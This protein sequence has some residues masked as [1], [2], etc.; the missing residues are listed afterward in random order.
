MAVSSRPPE[1]TCT[2]GSSWA[3]P[4]PA[5]AVR[6]SSS[7]A[8]CTPRQAVTMPQ[9]L[10]L[11]FHHHTHP[12]CGSL[13]EATRR[14]ACVRKK[15]PSSSGSSRSGSHPDGMLAKSGCPMI[16]TMAISRS[17]CAIPSGRGMWVFCQPDS[18][19]TWALST[20]VMDTRSPP[21]SVDGDLHDQVG[22]RG[23][24]PHLVD[25]HGQMI[26]GV[27]VDRLQV[28]DPAGGLLPVGDGRLVPAASKDRHPVAL[29]V[30]DDVVAVG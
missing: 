16:A 18:L 15:F 27:E 21:G 14:N 23:G 11:P 13:P 19:S 26:A 12:P 7:S 8:G 3:E 6:Y 4:A 22:A 10:K 17:P 29:D 24:R 28:G 20:N 5:V 30:H 25:V 1:R 9:F 2:A